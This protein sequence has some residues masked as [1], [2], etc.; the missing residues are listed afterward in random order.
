[1]IN[2]DILLKGKNTEKSKLITDNF[3]ESIIKL[4]NNKNQ[5]NLDTGNLKNFFSKGNIIYPY[6]R[7]FQ[8]VNR[9][10]ELDCCELI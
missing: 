6:A 4:A 7:S 9:F 1:M 2:N 5:N 8:L 10:K 3:I